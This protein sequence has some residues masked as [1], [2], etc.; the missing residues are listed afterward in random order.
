MQRHRESNL[1]SARYLYSWRSIQL[2][3][4]PSTGPRACVMTN[5]PHKYSFRFPFRVAPPHMPG[6]L[7][8]WNATA[9]EAARAL[10]DARVYREAA[11]VAQRFF[12]SFEFLLYNKVGEH[13]C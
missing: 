12:Y 3:T 4:R 1:A 11:R 10:R 13:L 2:A 5:E 8:D 6:R 7:P 9:G